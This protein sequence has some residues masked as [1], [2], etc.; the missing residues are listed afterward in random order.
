MISGGLPGPG[1]GGMTG[2]GIS[3]GIGVPGSVGVANVIEGMFF[4]RVVY[5]EIN[6]DGSTQL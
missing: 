4:R 3:V 2:G 6:G 5:P 1:I